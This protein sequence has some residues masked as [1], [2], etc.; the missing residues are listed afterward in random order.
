M[1]LVELLTTSVVHALRLICLR[2]NP[3]LLRLLHYTNFQIL[4]EHLDE[5]CARY[6]LNPPIEGVPVKNVVN[7][8]AK[9]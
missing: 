5:T 9:L 4:M 3:N 2:I 7:L 1:Q 8:V 6:F